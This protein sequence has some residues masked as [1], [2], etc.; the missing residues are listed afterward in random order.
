MVSAQPPPSAGPG[1]RAELR[2]LKGVGP[3]RAAELERAGLRTSDDLLHR[4]PLRYE[5]RSRLVRSSDLRPGEA[6]AIRG[7]V[8]S[9]GLRQT[10]RRGFSLFEMLLRD[11][12][13][14]FR[15]VWMNQPYLKTAFSAGQRVLLYGTAEWRDPGGLRLSNPQYELLGDGDGDEELFLDVG[16]NTGHSGVL[17]DWD[18]DACALRAVEDP[19]PDHT[20]GNG[21]MDR[22]S[23]LSL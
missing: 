21:R 18:A 12:A 15:A 10:R 6:A 17:L 23:R 16:G 20:G 4:F 22:P 5:D 19:H 14:T 13:G 11:D 3:R 2:F 7:T 8:V 1:L 9:T